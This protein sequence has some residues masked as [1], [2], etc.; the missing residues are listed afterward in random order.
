M[1]Y[2]FAVITELAWG[3]PRQAALG[4]YFQAADPHVPAQK[5]RPGW[6]ETRDDLPY[7]LM[8]AW[9]QDAAAAV[10]LAADVLPAGTPLAWHTQHY[11]LVG[12][13]LLSFFF[14]LPVL[15]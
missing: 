10:R 1:H 7:D 15:S 5:R 8:A 14:P 12:S 3:N 13:N 11:P 2:S 9:L 4:T 6:I